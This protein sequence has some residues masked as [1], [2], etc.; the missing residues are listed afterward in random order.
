MTP[1]QLEKALSAKGDYTGD[2]LERLDGKDR[3]ILSVLTARADASLSDKC[4]SM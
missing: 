2:P 3:V 4:L 1:C